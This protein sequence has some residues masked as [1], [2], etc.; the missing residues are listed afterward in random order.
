VIPTSDGGF[1]LA[2][3]QLSSNPRTRGTV[4]VK[5]DANGNM[6]CHDQSGAITTR[7]MVTTNTVT[8]ANISPATPL[9][10]TSY[11]LGV[12][13]GIVSELPGTSTTPLDIARDLPGAARIVRGIPHRR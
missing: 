10:I 2:R 9:S 13:D 3:N 7:W 4:P 5:S 12:L 11:G 1:L 6:T 8:A